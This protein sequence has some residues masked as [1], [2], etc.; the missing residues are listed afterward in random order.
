MR[1]KAEKGGC[2]L[3]LM[4]PASRSQRLREGANLLPESHSIQRRQGLASHMAE[5]SCRE[6]EVERLLEVQAHGLHPLH[7][8]PAPL[9]LRP[10]P[11]V[12]LTPTSLPLPRQVPHQPCHPFV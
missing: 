12:L 2:G 7:Y 11:T 10:P 3:E 6:G 1:E 4:G 9:S 5:A 8:L